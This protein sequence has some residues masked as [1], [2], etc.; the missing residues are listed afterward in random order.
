MPD[1]LHQLPS[2]TRRVLTF[3]QVL[4]ALALLLFAVTVTYLLVTVASVGD[5]PHLI[6]DGI[7]VELEGFEYEGNI[8]TPM[9]FF[10]IALM[11]FSSLPGIFALWVTFGLFAAYRRGEVFTVRSAKRLNLIGWLIFALA[12]VSILAGLIANAAFA[13]WAEPGDVSVNLSFEEGD[14]YAL[15]FGLLVVIV[16]HAMKQAVS[17]SEENKEFV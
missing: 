10:S 6:D 12:P 4:I 16:S 9:R 1:T 11:F 17:I 15:I 14:I 13:H 7:R 5:K 8:G 3:G 2:S